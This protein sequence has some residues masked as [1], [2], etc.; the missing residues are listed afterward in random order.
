MPP[1]SVSAL[2]PSPH[3][4]P[5][6]VDAI[7]TMVATVGKSHVISD[8]KTKDISTLFS[9]EPSDVSQLTST[10]Q[11]R[12][13]IQGRSTPVDKDLLKK[14]PSCN[15]NKASLGK[16]G[17]LLSCANQNKELR[18]CLKKNRTEK[19]CCSGITLFHLQGNAQEKSIDDLAVC[20]LEQKGSPHVRFASYDEVF[21]ITPVFAMDCEFSQDDSS[22]FVSP[23]KHSQTKQPTTSSIESNNVSSS[24]SKDKVE[25]IAPSCSNCEDAR[26]TLVS[27]TISPADTID[28]NMDKIEN[29]TRVSEFAPQSKDSELVVSVGL[30][31]HS[32]FPKSSIE[33]QKQELVH[34]VEMKSHTP[35]KRMLAIEEDKRCSYNYCAAD[36]AAVESNENI[37]NEIDTVHGQKSYKRR[38]YTEPERLQNDTSMDKNCEKNLDSSFK[39]QKQL[40]FETEHDNKLC[41]TI[42]TKKED[43]IENYR[44]PYKIQEIDIR[45]ANT[46]TSCSSSQND[47]MGNLFGGLLAIVTGFGSREAG[48]VDMQD[49]V[50]SILVDHGGKVLESLQNIPEV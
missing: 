41:D 9:S 33:N 42:E 46:D 18:S 21:D 27:H 24:S 45:V 5:Q 40:L 22:H 25:E 11:E 10:C 20:E 29:T 1:D 3:T 50:L 19:E 32:D 15:N 14:K 36:C 48:V 6:H 13:N 7:Y 16:H 44:S 23:N 8:N 26:E 12:G 30:S 47:S 31:Y 4:G 49:N 38:R 43:D 34:T 2:E 37:K 35:H 28:S 39:V 17:P